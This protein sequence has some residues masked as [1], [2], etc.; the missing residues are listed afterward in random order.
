MSQTIHPELEGVLEESDAVLIE[1][2]DDALIGFVER[3]GMETP[4]ALYDTERVLEILME[5]EGMGAEEAVDFFNVNILQAWVGPTSPAF[6]T[7]RRPI[8]ATVEGSGSAP[9]SPGV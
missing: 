4:V 5:T 9:S 2:F 6:A 3:I 8:A 1:G 7:L